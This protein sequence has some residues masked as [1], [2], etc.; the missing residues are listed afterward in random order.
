MNKLDTT[1]AATP[2]HAIDAVETVASISVGSKLQVSAVKLKP[3]IDHH[4]LSTSKDTLTVEVL[5][6]GMGTTDINP[7]KV[8]FIIIEI[9]LIDNQDPALD[10]KIMN[11][12]L[13]DLVTIKP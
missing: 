8:V 7:N 10:G 13:A 1:N 6:M 5:R 3:F 11:V 12:G 2:T 9:K 4:G